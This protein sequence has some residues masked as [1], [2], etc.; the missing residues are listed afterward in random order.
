MG[1]DRDERTGCPD[2]RGAE[3]FQDDRCRRRTDFRNEW[4]VPQLPGRIASLVTIFSLPS[5]FPRRSPS[6]IGA[7]LPDAAGNWRGLSLG[8]RNWILK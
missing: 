1:A 5:R 8:C 7:A 2:Q 3:R 4:I 6:S